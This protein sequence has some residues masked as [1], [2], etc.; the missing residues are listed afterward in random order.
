MSFLGNL[1]GRKKTNT[2]ILPA[3]PCSQQQ[4]LGLFDGVAKTIVDE[5]SATSTLVKG[6][7]VVSLTDAKTMALGIA[8]LFQQSEG[9]NIVYL[10]VMVLVHPG[11]GKMGLYAKGPDGNQAALEWLMKDQKQSYVLRIERDNLDY[12]KQNQPIWS[13]VKKVIRA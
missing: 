12:L 6:D 7:V 1:F 2:T 4:P 8:G 5:M 13:R 3:G 10:D 9:D 11:T